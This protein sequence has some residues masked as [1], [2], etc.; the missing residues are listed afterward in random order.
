MI[1]NECEDRPWPLRRAFGIRR[2][3]LIAATLILSLGFHSLAGVIL[4]WAG[5]ADRI[6]PALEQLVLPHG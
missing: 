4:Q 5:S 1:A 2:P 3:P 6:A